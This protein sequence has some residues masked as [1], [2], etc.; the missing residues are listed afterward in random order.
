[1]RAIASTRTRVIGASAAVLM[2]LLVASSVSAA[3]GVILVPDNF[4]PALS[5]TRATGHYQVVGT[6]LHV[7][8]QSNTSTDKVAEYVATN[9]PLSGVGEPNLELTNAA[10][11]IP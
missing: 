9:V 11:T 1:M 6:G 10:G 4:V 5:D 7:W 8:T 2:T 3:A